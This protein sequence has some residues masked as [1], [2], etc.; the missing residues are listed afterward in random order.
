MIPKYARY[1]YCIQKANEF[2]L[3]ENISFFPFDSD[4]IILKNKWARKKYTSLALEN[5]CTLNDVIE[6]FGSEDAYSIFNGRNY[7]IS[8]NDKQQPKRIY[9]TKLH[10]IGHIYLNHFCEFEETRL[11][12]SNISN[13]QYKVLENEANCFARNVLAPAFL[14]KSLNLNTISKIADYFKITLSAA[15]ARL[16]LLEYDY[17][18][19]VNSNDKILFNL[20]KKFNLKIS[21]SNCNHNFLYNN[22]INYCP[23]CG[24]NNFKYGDD[25]MMYSQIELNEYN[26]TKICPM[27]ENELTNIKGEY[28][29]ICGLNITNKC[30]NW[31]CQE[32]LSGSARYCNYCGAE[33]TFLQDGILKNWQSENPYFVNPKNIES[34][35]SYESNCISEY[36]DIPF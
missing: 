21:C 25:I 13:S 1:D 18:Y 2:L 15:K 36:D 7:T 8:Y 5:N 31:N 32:L 17:K 4:P 16:D 24:T 6:A 35:E 26:K 10:E 30:S 27:C 19:I 11:N 22:S 12:R 9:F 23:I 20:C 34:D 3:K 28:C 29:Q 33:S 14:V